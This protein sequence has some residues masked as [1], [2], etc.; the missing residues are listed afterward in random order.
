[1]PSLWPKPENP[2]KSSFRTDVATAKKDGP[3]NYQLDSNN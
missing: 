3:N 1:M 2:G